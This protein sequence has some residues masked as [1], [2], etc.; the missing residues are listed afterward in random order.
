M[1]YDGSA[2]PNLDHELQGKFIVRMYLSAIEKKYFL[3]YGMIGEWK[4]IRSK[5]RT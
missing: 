4:Y 2:T 5:A 1:W 3:Q